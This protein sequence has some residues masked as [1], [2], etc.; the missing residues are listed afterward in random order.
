MPGDATADEATA[1]YDHGILTVSV[2]LKAAKKD[3]V[4]KIE[5]KPT[6]KGPRR[7]HGTGR[8]RRARPVSCGRV[9]CGG[10]SVTAEQDIRPCPTG[11]GGRIVKAY[12][13]AIDGGH[14]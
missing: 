3:E 6:K 2:G 7:H 4:K 5:V 14:R 1:S 9:S 11:S 10:P 13:N 8:A 12:V